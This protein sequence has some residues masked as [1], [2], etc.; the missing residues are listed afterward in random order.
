MTQIPV[1]AKPQNN[2]RFKVGPTDSFEMHVS[3]L[4]LDSKD[5]A[6]W[7]GGTPDA[8]LIDEEHEASIT[9]IQ[10]WDDPESFCRFAF[11]HAGETLPYEYKPHAEDAFTLYG[12]M[13]LRRPKVGGKTGQRNEST[14]VCPSSE[15]STTAPT[16]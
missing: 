8:V 9:F 7:T 11:E 15:P 12:T 2:I 13:T 5:G 4:E 10:A 3:S 1:A 16:P 6:K 14:I